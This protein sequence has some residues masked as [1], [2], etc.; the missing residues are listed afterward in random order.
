[1]EE[2]A[3]CPQLE[4]C[5]T[6]KPSKQ[7][8]RKRSGNSEGE[9][10]VELMPSSKTSFEIPTAVQEEGRKCPTTESGGGSGGGDKTA[11]KRSVAQKGKSVKQL[12]LDWS[13]EESEPVREMWEKDMVDQV[14]SILR[15]EIEEVD[16]D[17]GEKERPSERKRNVAVQMDPINKAS[18]GCTEKQH[19][20]EEM[21]KKKKKARSSDSTGRSAFSCLREARSENGPKAVR[22]PQN[23]SR[24]KKL[25]GSTATMLQDTPPL[26]DAPSFDTTLPAFE[27]AHNTSKNQKTISKPSTGAV[28]FNKEKESLNEDP[29]A[30]FVLPG[31]D[32]ED[33]PAEKKS[34]TRGAAKKPVKII[35][36][37]NTKSSESRVSKYI[38][39]SEERCVDIIRKKPK[40][41][42]CS[43]TGDKKIKN[44]AKEK[45]SSQKRGDK[46]KAPKRSITFRDFTNYDHLEILP[47]NSVNLSRSV[48]DTNDVGESSKKRKFFKT[49]AI[50][51]HLMKR[52]GNRLSVSK[53]NISGA[54]RTER[55]GQG[56]SRRR[57][58]VDPAAIA[59]ITLPSVSETS[60]LRHQEPIQAAK[61]PRMTDASTSPDQDLVVL[62]VEEFNKFL[63]LIASGIKLATTT[64]G[65]SVAQ[66][67]MAEWMT[68]LENRIPLP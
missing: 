49:I 66:K 37:D 62:R 32:R 58:F 4:Q 5:R 34:K 7:Q 19:E 22:K 17:D 63:Q 24:K 56:V 20:T 57:S 16:R 54:P 29:S 52:S 21:V 44:G 65:T 11:S 35:N 67:E 42:N 25:L 3:S 51:D 48:N 2:V 27:E 9:F 33:E 43:T 40:G 26:L 61:K 14:T 12:H 23:V 60:R 28:S 36:K 53:V 38:E 1:M 30:D 47:R 10:Q 8:E 50:P 59:R 31:P 39:R 68:K 46:R 45:N 15:P 41:K 13:E 64:N 18:E 55:C 6:D